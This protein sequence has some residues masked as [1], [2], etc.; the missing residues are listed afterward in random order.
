MS[1]SVA[2][3]ARSG[4]RNLSASGGGR[5]RRRPFGVLCR[6][7]KTSTYEAYA[8]RAT[9]Q[10]VGGGIQTPAHWLRSRPV[11]APPPPCAEGRHAPLGE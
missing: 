8:L 11:P 7:L 6:G 2:S 1:R 10:H 5:H 9:R 4:D 3:G